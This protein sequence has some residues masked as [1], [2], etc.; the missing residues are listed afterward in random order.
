MMLHSGWIYSWL[1]M[2]RGADPDPEMR[3]MLGLS[4]KTITFPTYHLTFSL[5]IV[6]IVFTFSFNLK[7]HILGYLTWRR[8][9]L[10]IDGVS[11][12]T[13]QNIWGYLRIF[14]FNSHK[15]LVLDHSPQKC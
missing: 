14:L 2:K 4:D 6:E 1:T 10:K 11:F 3:H 15:K 13:L 9:I 8:H 5:H 12:L 7:C